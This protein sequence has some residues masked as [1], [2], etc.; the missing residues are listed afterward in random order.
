MKIENIKENDMSTVNSTSCLWVTPSFVSHFFGLLL[1]TFIV[2]CIIKRSSIFIQSFII[3]LFQLSFQ[4][5]MLHFKTKFS[6]QKG[7]RV[8]MTIANQCTGE[9]N[10]LFPFLMKKFK[11]IKITCIFSIC[12]YFLPQ[13][14][15]YL[16]Q[17]YIIFEM[18][19]I[20]KV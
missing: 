7:I 4:F 2:Q 19:S 13:K 14:I 3:N 16:L 1:L 6:A 8:E 11:P 10:H 17:I 15:V 5:L 20:L 12:I 9:R 18:L